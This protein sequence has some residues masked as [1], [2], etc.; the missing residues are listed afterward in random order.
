M[1]LSWQS[2]DLVVGK[3]QPV[4]AH[5]ESGLRSFSGF[6]RVMVETHKQLRIILRS[7]LKAGV[8]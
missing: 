1:L 5:M 8:L 3:G 2:R 4:Q 6:F 7:V